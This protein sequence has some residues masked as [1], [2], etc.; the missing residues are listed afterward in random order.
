MTHRALSMFRGG[1]PLPAAA[2]HLL[3]RS[4]LIVLRPRTGV[5]NG[6]KT[7]ACTVSSNANGTSRLILACCHAKTTSVTRALKEGETKQFQNSFEPS[8][9]RTADNDL[10][11]LCL[12]KGEKKVTW[13]NENNRMTEQIRMDL[14]RWFMVRFNKLNFGVKFSN[15]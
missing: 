5:N 13:V 14:F 10:C 2:E 9:W 7:K 1:R 6:G 4:L 11:L 3:Y 12:W 15:F 8:Q